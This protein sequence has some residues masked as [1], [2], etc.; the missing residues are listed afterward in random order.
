M[1][2]LL[3]LDIGTTST[4]GILIDT[5]GRILAIASRPS[6]LISEHPNWAEEEPAEWWDN[7]RAII[8]ELLAGTGTAPGTIAAVGVTGMVPAVV[9]LDA[10]GRPLRRSMQ[11]N[12]ARAVAEIAAL[13]GETDEAAF[14][15]R[16][17]GG[18]NQQ[19]VAPKLRWLE[20]HEPK[21]FADIATVLGS[22]DYIAYR[23]TGHLQVEQ[24]WALESGLMAL[25][26][27]QFHP[28]L[29]ALA[30]I[31]ADLLPPIR[32]SHE[33]VGEVSAAAA[34]ATGLSPGTPVVAGCADHVASAYVAG[35]VAD[36]D[37]VLKFG[38]AGDILLSTSTPVT[39]PRLFIDYH[40]V[41]G[42][43]FSNG[44]MAAS[45]SL[46]N[47]IA[48]ELAAAEAE[49]ARA[50]GE[51]VHARLDRLAAQVP[52]GADGVVLLPYFLGEKTPLH[53][54][55][56]R[57][58]LI[59]LGLHHRLAHVWRAALEGVVFGFRHHVDVFA[60]R[61]LA[62][63][64]VVACD[65]GAAS[66]LWLHIAADVLDRPV[67]RLR[68][69]PGSSLGAAYVAGYGVGLF[70]DW[71]GIAAYVAPGELFTPDPAHRAPYDRAYGIYRELYDRLQTLFPRLTAPS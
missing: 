6:R 16:T 55:H 20:T 23:L 40:I 34:S 29:V 47:W 18:I 32:R 63:G 21:L 43:Y 54:P 68:N 45:G 1:P 15:A 4:I 7:C 38:G 27:G 37:L 9:L 14:F 61:G 49:R 41:P 58:T 44:C 10:A 17:G 11:Q 53:D 39:D 12:D 33:V 70:K 8:A 51:S 13:K 42:L 24:N 3:G 31:A 71:A 67:Q 59:G 28:E 26:T 25:A 52:A 64:R 66:D 2:A 35:A 19:L 60:E 69:H 46:L 50:A 36:G 57:G 65:G 30:G 5:A 56:A 48:R 62:V 22:Y